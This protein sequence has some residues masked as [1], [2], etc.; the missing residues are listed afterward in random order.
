MTETKKQYPYRYSEE[1]EKLFEKGFDLYKSEN[2]TPKFS[3]NQLFDICLRKA[4]VFYPEHVKNMKAEINRL[5]RQ[6]QE[7]EREKVQILSD[8]TILKER[9][10][11]KFQLDIELQKMVNFKQT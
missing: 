6:L 5:N 8:Y 1:I 2:S 7:A 4:I 11:K 9:L 3:M 10:N